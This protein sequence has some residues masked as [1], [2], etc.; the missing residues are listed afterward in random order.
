MPEI[1]AADTGFILLCAALVLFMTPGLALFYGGMV[2]RKNVLGTIMHSFFMIGI[3]SIV[4]LIVGYSLAFGPDHGG[5]VGGFDWFGLKGVGMAPN[6]DYAKTIPH[7]CFMIYQCM[8]AVITPALITG[9]FAERIKFSSFLVFSIVWA[10]LVY[11]PVAHWVWGTHGWLKELGVLDFAGGTVVH[12]NSAA[13][14]L[15]AAICVGRRKGYRVT[16]M[17]PHNLT[18]TVLGA[19]ILW[20]GWFGFN[21]GSAL[22]ANGVAVNAF[23]VTHAA[24]AAGMLSWVF[25]EWKHHGKPTTLGAAS[26]C[27]AGLATIT[28]ASGFVSPMAAIVIGLLAGAVCY[29]GV[30][31]KWKL[32]YDDA[33][34]V[35]GVHGVGST[36]GILATGV[37]ASKL[38]NDAGADG[39]LHGNAG[40]LGVQALAIAATIVYSFGI[41]FIVLKVL[42]KTMGLRLSEESEEIGLDLAAHGEEGYAW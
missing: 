42:D 37:F 23:I 29:F 38:I 31:L 7:S 24:A 30:L 28:P 1:N 33:L 41:S 22:A 3:I 34:D 17:N 40:L 27:V 15:A 18:M 9:A 11:S 32:K 21:A 14:A 20:F 16:P 35:V 10:L 26:G 6:P 13:A 4:W 25:I 8:F 19:G 36:L 12:I 39:L 2:R 5:F